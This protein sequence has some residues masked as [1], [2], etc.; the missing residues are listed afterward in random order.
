MQSWLNILLG[1]MCANL[2]KIYTDEALCYNA[3]M[4][5]DT[6]H[7]KELLSK[8]LSI[9][10][11]ELLSVGQKNPEKVG[12]WQTVRKDGGDTT[13]EGD[14]AEEIEEFENNNAILSKLEL[15][16]NEV[17]NALAKINNGTYG[18]C[19]VCGKEIEGDRLEANPSA[20]T[21]KE[22]MN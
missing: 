16:L 2:I 4:T 3:H 6:N 12:D 21:C 17:K 5:L 1:K 10:E 22:H 20:R 11:S 18:K 13:E 9:L 14:L 19:E 8:E 7:F 15:R